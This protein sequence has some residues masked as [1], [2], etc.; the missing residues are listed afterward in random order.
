VEAEAVPSDQDQ[1]EATTT[2]TM[3]GGKNLFSSNW[4]EPM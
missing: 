1:G 4:S 3:A 2:T